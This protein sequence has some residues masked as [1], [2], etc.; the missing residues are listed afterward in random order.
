M[1]KWLPEAVGGRLSG[2]SVDYPGMTAGT[3]AV[4]MISFMDCAR[5]FPNRRFETGTA[6]PEARK[7]DNKVRFY[8]VF[9]PRSA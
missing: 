7:L 2:V 9:V 1:L 3:W 4:S 8:Q 5:S 6:G